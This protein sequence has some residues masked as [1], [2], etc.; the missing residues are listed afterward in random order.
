[1]LRLFVGAFPPEDVA[2][3]LHRAV[4]E[5]L[6]DARVRLVPPEEIHLTLRFLG[7]TEEAAVAEIRRELERSLARRPAARLRIRGAG[8]FPAPE[9]AKVLWVGLEGPY[10]RLALEEAWTPHLTVARAAGD[11]RVRVPP[12]FLEIEL[13]LAWVLDEVRL[14]DSRPGARGPERFQTIAAFPLSR[15]SP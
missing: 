4:R 13:A 3:E 12:A 14:V 1:V 10:E 9:R 11:A 6:A 5:T 7:A 8:A 15:E 2:A